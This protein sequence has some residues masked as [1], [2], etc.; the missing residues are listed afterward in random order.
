MLRTL[1]KRLIY[2]S[3]R[4]G[5]GG[6]VFEMYKFRTLKPNSNVSMFAGNEAYTKFG[7]F[8]RKTK[9]DELPSL[10]NVL[11]GQMGI[12]GY[13]PEELRTWNIYSP[14]IKDL[15]SQ[16]KPGLMDLSSVHFFDEEKI[17]QMFPDKQKAY[18]E[19]IFPIKMA[20]RAF[21]FENKSI[22]L[23]LAI[24]WIVIKKMIKSLFRK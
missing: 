5:R 19:K 11:R 9:L 23:K 17:L 4:V 16:Y 8:L 21:Y 10:I 15:L 6:S 14:E 1:F 3:E 20:L 18:W 7:R 12:F 22:P 13:R 2:K 24:L